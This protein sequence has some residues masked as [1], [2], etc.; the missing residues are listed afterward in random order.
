MFSG[1]INWPETWAP[2]GMSIIKMTAPSNMHTA[3]TKVSGEIW[4]KRSHDKANNNIAVKTVPETYRRPERD[5][6]L[7]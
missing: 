5:A 7:D 2:E 3:E 6:P 1:E 4:R